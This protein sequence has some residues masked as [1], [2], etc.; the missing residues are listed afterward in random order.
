M[1]IGRAVTKRSS[2]CVRC[3][4]VSSVEFNG[5]RRL[6]ALWGNGDH[7]RL[8]HGSLESQ[9]RPNVLPSSAFHNQNL[10]QIACGG[11]H[12]LF[13]TDHGRVYACG[14]N[15]Y[16]QLGVSD[17]RAYISEPLGVA[18]LPKE[19]VKVSAGCH[20]SSAITE[21][22]TVLSIPNKVE[23]LN[24]VTIKI[25]SLGFEH[26]IA[27]TDKGETLSWGG[28]QSGRLG[29]G[30]QSGIFGL[31][32][33]D[34]EYTPRLIKELEGLKVKN[35]SAGMLHSVCI[36]E[37]GSVHIFGER[38]NKKLGFSEAS[39]CSLPSVV[40]GLPYAEKA[41]CGGYHTCVITGGGELYVWGTNENGCLGIGSTDVAHLPER[42]EG[43]FLRHS[44]SEVSCGWKHTAA[45]SGGNVYTWGWGG[46]H[47]TF[48]VDGHS[49]GGQLGQGNDVDYIKPTKI[50]FRRHVKALQVSCGFNHTGAIFEYN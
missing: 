3:F 50:N 2:W 39:N 12:S 34:S 31:I 7:G 33:S 29:H 37:N 14:L 48:S 43:P 47:G 49:S 26:S 44:V 17:D 46:S 23:C 5:N 25:I 41:A 45:I 20:H 16:G 30:H 36:S 22:D 1:I 40:D 4:S 6:A 32:K 28:G 11:A 8:G 38:A 13:L 15:D 10:R 24:G 27:V 21:A 42:V 9:W 35:A 18:G 19:I